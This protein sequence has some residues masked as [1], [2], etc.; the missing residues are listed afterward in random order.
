MVEIDTRKCKCGASM[1]RVGSEIT[2]MEN[3]TGNRMGKLLPTP[4]S[5]VHWECKSCGMQLSDRFGFYVQKGTV[6][7]ESWF[8]PSDN[9]APLNLRG[10]NV[11][12]GS[13]DD[14]DFVKED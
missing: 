13:L 11:F 3:C 7:R 14:A 1:N 10:R 2:C 9:G 12:A 6:P 5:I 4:A 8:M